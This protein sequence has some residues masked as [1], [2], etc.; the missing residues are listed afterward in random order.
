MKTAYILMVFTRVY[1]GHAPATVPGF[2]TLE[3]CE[4]AASVVLERAKDFPYR[5]HAF[6][7]SAR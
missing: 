7:I 1:Y 2:E 4:R 6:C 3:A 5:V